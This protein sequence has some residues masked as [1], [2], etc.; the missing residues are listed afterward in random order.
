MGVRPRRDRAAGPAPG[1]RPRGAALL[2][3]IPRRFKADGLGQVVDPGRHHL[4]VAR[5]ENPTSRSH[6]VG[7]R[8]RP[9]ADP[10]GEEFRGPVFLDGLR[11]G[12]PSAFL[13]VE[14]RDDEEPI[15]VRLFDAIS[16]VHDS[17]GDDRSRIVADLDVGR[18]HDDISSSRRGLGLLRGQVAGE[19]REDE[20][21]GH[22]RRRESRGV[23]SHRGDLRSLVGSARSTGAAHPTVLGVANTVVGCAPPRGAG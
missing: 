21:A 12:H 7:I 23:D 8:V 15:S 2:E 16:F 14:G 20:E 13:R 11:L 3:S 22:H 5:G 10:L 6:D 1:R 17:S 18:G 9:G 19:E 4:R